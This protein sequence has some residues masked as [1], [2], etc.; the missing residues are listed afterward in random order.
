M[1]HIHGATPYLPIRKEAIKSLRQKALIELITNPVFGRM[2]F[3]DSVLQSSEA[4]EA[5][6]HTTLARLANKH[7]LPTTGLNYLIAGGAE[8]A[9]ARELF[10]YFPKKITMV[11]WDEELVEYMK[12]EGWHKGAFSD[13]RLSVIHEDIL[14]FLERVWSI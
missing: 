13:S 1:F 12:G 14:I 7:Y 3:I 11:D 2:L 5:I 8:G 6:Y 10:K 4:D 9:M